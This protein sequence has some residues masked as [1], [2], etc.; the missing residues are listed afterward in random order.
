M[1]NP[2]SNA[3]IVAVFE[4]DLLSN[5][6]IYAAGAL[7]AFEYLITMR[8]EHEFLFQRK[9]TAGTWLFI[10]NRY[11]L[12]ISVI[13][14]CAPEG[15]QNFITFVEN[16][17]LIISAVFS[18]LRVFALLDHA[19]MTAGCVLL[20]GLAQIAFISYTS[21]QITW[22]YIDEVQ[23]LGSSC[24]GIQNLPAS[25]NFKLTTIAS[26]VI[27]ILVTWLK[28]YRHVREAT[29]IGA[30]VSFSAV[31]IQY[32]TL[33]F[34]VLLGVTIL[35]LITLLKPSLGLITYATDAFVS[36]L[37]SILTSRFLINL[38][39]AESVESRNIT[40]FSHFSVPRFHVPS[41]PEIIG[42]LGERLVDGDEAVG[43]EEQSHN[44]ECGEEHP[45]EI[46]D[47]ER[48]EAA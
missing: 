7:A 20:L 29:D 13:A 45:I 40:R 41:L 43:D 3:A 44:A 28:T 19:Y 10:A 42:N 11:T 33:Y 16:I 23:T 36:V 14:Q 39:Q 25:V 31:L 47:A 48:N 26:E 21:S 24:Y 1:S 8:Y 38:R 46:C 22:F 6:C 27:V 30:D 34:I 37:P 12:L 5:Q 17:P 35:P 18:A 32:G 9:W 4:S 15:A 2:S